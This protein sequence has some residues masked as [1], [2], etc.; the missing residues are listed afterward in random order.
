MLE[1][2]FKLAA[3]DIYIPQKQG[4]NCLSL[5]NYSRKL[6]ISLLCLTYYLLQLYHTAL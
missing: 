2:L 5:K 4:M 6:K 1:T 3:T